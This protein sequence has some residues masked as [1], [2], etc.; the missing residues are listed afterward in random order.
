MP[1]QS[2]PLPKLLTP[3]FYQ[4][5]K[6]RIT[7]LTTT[8]LIIVVKAKVILIETPLEV[9]DNH[10]VQIHV[11]IFAL[12][13]LLHKNHVIS[14]QILVVAVN[15]AMTNMIENLLHTN[16]T[17]HVDVM[18]LNHHVVLKHVRHVLMNAPQDT[19]IH[20]LDNTNNHIVHNPSDALIVI[21]LIVIEVDRIRIL[22]IFQ[23][24]PIN[25]PLT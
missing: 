16:I 7:Y 6:P 1:K 18:I 4:H 20:R 22:I 10:F 19:I 13:I 2:K 11:L 3:S 24:V 23:I 12:G 9:Y 17:L 15:P 14:A 21:E 25:P 5:F 8:T